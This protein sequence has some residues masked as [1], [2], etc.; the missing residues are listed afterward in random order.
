MTQFRFSISD[1][2]D[3]CFLCYRY[4]KRFELTK[5][6]PY[7]KFSLLEPV[8]NLQVKTNIISRS[9]TFCNSVTAIWG[10]SATV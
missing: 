4:F 2:L 3:L 10:C 7:Q 6:E 9:Q 5:K 1:A 8:T